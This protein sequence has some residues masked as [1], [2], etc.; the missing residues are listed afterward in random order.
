M[1]PPD[2]PSLLSCSTALDGE[3][4]LGSEGEVHLGLLDPPDVL[5]G[6]PRG[7]LLTA[8]HY[9]LYPLKWLLHH[10]LPDVMLKGGRQKYVS[11]LFISVL[12]L[13]LLSYVMIKCCDGLGQWIGTS[14]IVMGLTLSAIGTSFPNLWSSMLVARQGLGNMAVSNAFGSNTFNI[15]IALGLPWFCLVVISGDPYEKMRDDG[16]VFMVVLLMAILVLFYLAILLNSWRIKYWMS[17]Y[18]VAVY[19]GVM[20]YAILHG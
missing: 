11:C 17:Y 13:A 6:S 12:W 10:S 7:M 1:V 3:L 2:L 9:V 20:I 19:I 8:S 15:C 4:H 14:P 5:F 18:F 16:I